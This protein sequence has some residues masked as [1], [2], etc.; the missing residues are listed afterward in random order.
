MRLLRI[1]IVNVVAILLIVLFI[2]RPYFTGEKILSPTAFY[3][4][5]WYSLLI[6]ISIVAGI[7]LVYK[8][9][10]FYHIAESHI[11]R[12]TLYG[13]IAGISG[14]RLYYVIFKWAFF[15]RHPAYILYIWKGGLA[16]HGAILSIVVIGYI[17]A[18]KNR[19][20]F[21]SLGDMFA[22]AVV[23]GQSIG[24]WGNFFNYEAFGYPTTLP[25]KMFVP[26]YA[27]PENFRKYNFFHPTFLYESLCDITIFY[28]LLH[29]ESKVP[30]RRGTIMFSYFLMYSTARFFIEGLRTDSLMFDGMR[31]AQIVSIFLAGLSALWLIKKKRHQ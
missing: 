4:I 2:A 24:R 13:I 25:W 23:L 9:A 7:F 10:H 21:L 12:L 1:Y 19:I 20:S 11:D 27:R 22:P 18:K 6:A 31:V 8:R 30:K 16:I 29:I 17:Y 26:I 15:S 28:I 5:R 3:S 14:A